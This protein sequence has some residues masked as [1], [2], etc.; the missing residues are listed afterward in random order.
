M[1]LRQKVEHYTGLLPQAE[2]LDF[3]AAWRP[4]SFKSGQ[5]LTAFGQVEDYFYYVLSGVQRGYFMHA[6]NEVCV[7][8]A[9]HPDFSGSYDSFLSRQ[10]ATYALQALADSELMGIHYDDLQMFYARYVWVERFGRLFNQQMFLRK[11]THEVAVLTYSAEE[12]FKRLWAAA[13]HLFQLVPQKHLASYL[14]MT[15]ETFSRLRAKLK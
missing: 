12:R 2:W 15:P 1:T 10:P 11:A 7:G 5:H 8:F 13:P 9:Y 6:G 4:F 14:G 3:E